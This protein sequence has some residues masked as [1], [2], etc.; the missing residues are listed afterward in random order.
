MLF[1]TGIFKRKRRKY[2]RTEAIVLLDLYKQNK[3]TPEGRGCVM[4]ISLGGSR[5]ESTSDFHVDEDIVLYFT[6]KNSDVF[7]IEGIVRRKTPSTGTFS[8]GI[9]FKELG[10]FKRMK[11][12]RLIPKILGTTS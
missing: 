3:L 5:I 10:F 8:Y 9:Q 7:V 11:L 6:L 2:E 1:N 12:R 4:D